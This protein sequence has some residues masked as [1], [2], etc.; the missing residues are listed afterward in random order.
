MTIKLHG[1]ALSPFVRKT[2]VV[3][4]LKNIAYQ[5]VHVDPTNLPEGFER[6]SPMRRIPVLEVNDTFLADSAAICVW[7]EGHQP[8]PS[9][10]PSDPL[11]HARCVWFERYADYDLAVNTTFSVFRNR[12]LMPLIGKPGNEERVNKA[13]HEVL[14]G[15]FEYLESQLQDRPYLC[16]EHMTV[17][18]IAVASQMVNF[19][20]G[21]ERLD[22]ERYPA[23]AAYLDTL[24][25][26]PPFAETIAKESAFVQQVSA[27]R[28]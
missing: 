13:L 24:H 11:L 15:M 21:G 19:A 10:Y 7:A 22:P 16:G 8:S 5:S 1:A 4:G 2:R 6:I 14:P 26:L 3:L 28:K 9:L 17:A 18:D 23:F 25:A 20:H 12:F 27:A